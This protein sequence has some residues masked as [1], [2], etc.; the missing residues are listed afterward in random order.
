MYPR[1]QWNDEKNQIGVNI[2]K[3]DNFF[4]FSISEPK[5]FVMS[6][7]GAISIRFDFDELFTVICENSVNIHRFRVLLLL[8]WHK[9]CL[10]IF[11]FGTH[12][13]LEA[14]KIYNWLSEWFPS[15]YLLQLKR[16]FHTKYTIRA[17]EALNIEYRISNTHFLYTNTKYLIIVVL[18][19]VN[20]IRIIFNFKE[21]PSI[22][23]V[24]CQYGMNYMEKIP[25]YILQYWTF[26]CIID[27]LS[28]NERTQLTTGKIETCFT[29]CFCLG[30]QELLNMTTKTYINKMIQN[31]K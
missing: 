4:R 15:S 3:I 5:E 13:R 31:Y 23:T 16:I 24:G 28:L 30:H 14:I 18:T 9:W 2:H 20:S 21:L 25:I 8:D 11:F 29:F 12:S 10:K 6:L 7:L 17:F 19:L 26:I 27:R 1:K 22:E